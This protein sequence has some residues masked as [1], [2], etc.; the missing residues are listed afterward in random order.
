MKRFCLGIIVA[1]GLTLPAFALDGTRSPNNVPPVV[2]PLG[3][4]Q[5]QRAAAELLKQAAQLRHDADK[6]LAQ[7]N[8]GGATLKEQ[9][10]GAWAHVSC[11]IQAFPWC[12]GPHDGIAILDA[13][14]HYA[15]VNTARGRPKFSE[16]ARRRDAYSAEEYK[17]AT[18]GLQAQFGTWSVNEADKTITLHIDGA[19]FPNVE[20]TDGKQTVSVSGDEVTLVSQFG[21]NVWRRIKK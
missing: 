3:S 21:S 18:M 19:I 17:A 5:L 8:P 15:I 16:P 1:V 11:T 13:S 7:A 9:L 6:L 12:L 10:V 2:E 14:G 4:I 20:G